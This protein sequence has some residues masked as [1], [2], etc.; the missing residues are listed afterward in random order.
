MDVGCK[1]CPECYTTTTT[2]VAKSRCDICECASDPFG[3]NLPKGEICSDPHC[4]D[5]SFCQT[6]VTT[7]TTLTKLTGCSAVCHCKDCWDTADMCLDNDC[8]NCP[9][10]NVPATT[11][12]STTPH[13]VKSRCEICE[14][15]DEKLGGNLPKGEVC[16]D[17]HC[18]DCAF[19]QTT[20]TTTTTLTKLTGCSAVCH[21]H[22]Y[23]DTADMCLDNDCRNCPEC[24]VPS[25]TTTTQSPCS[26]RE[27]AIDKGLLSKGEACLDP[28]CENCKF[29]FTTTTTTV[30]TKVLVKTCGVWSDW[31]ECVY[32]CEA[33]CPT[34]NAVYAPAVYAAPGAVVNAAPA[35]APASG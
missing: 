13:P 25:T 4:S 16:S 31:S 33:P 24:H 28:H 11:T 32:T 20:I 34:N 14:C 6:T 10:C 21:C 35:A 2:T 27:C 22:D 15:A 3:G 9:E 8:R 17:H 1:N 29:C 30:T 18:S 12:K 26:I 23:W 5:C 7:T 19:C